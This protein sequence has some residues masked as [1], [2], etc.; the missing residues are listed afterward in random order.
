[1]AKRN[2]QK[3]ATVHYSIYRTI[4]GEETNVTK[5][6]ADSFGSP[7]RAIEAAKVAVRF[8]SEWNE[9]NLVKV[10]VIDKTTKEVLWSYQA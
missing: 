5:K 4:R 7:E 9:A 1:M 6:H 2:Y 8:Y 3:V 10:E